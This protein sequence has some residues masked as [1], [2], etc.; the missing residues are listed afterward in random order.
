MLA[1]RVQE[2]LASAKGAVERDASIGTGVPKMGRFWLLSCHCT[3]KGPE[4]NEHG[5]A[6]FPAVAEGRIDHHRVKIR[7]L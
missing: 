2:E 7:L 6:R 4:P 5:L 1:L 3:C